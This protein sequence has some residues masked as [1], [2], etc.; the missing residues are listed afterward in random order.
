M[1]G[2]I[3]LERVDVSLFSTD[4]M[5]WRC[6]FVPWLFTAMPW[7]FI[8]HYTP[9][10]KTFVLLVPYTG[11]GHPD[12]CNPPLVWQNSLLVHGEGNTW[13][14]PPI[15]GEDNTW[16]E[17]GRGRGTERVVL[18]ST[19]AARSENPRPFFLFAKDMTLRKRGVGGNEMKFADTWLIFINLK[20][21][22]DFGC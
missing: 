21:F 4:E 19:P 1:V 2:I 16:T 9:P 15:H 14:E 20:D 6:I 17:R 18:R 12:T 10:K 5:Q 3:Y 22:W 8:C 13:T 11:N 7:Y